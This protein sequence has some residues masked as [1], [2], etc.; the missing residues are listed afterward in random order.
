MVLNSRSTFTTYPKPPPPLAQ[1]RTE[2]RVYMGRQTWYLV[3]PSSTRPHLMHTPRRSHE[4]VSMQHSTLRL[5]PRGSRALS[6]E[7]KQAWCAKPR[8][9]VN[10]GGVPYLTPLNLRI[11]CVIQRIAAKRHHSLSATI[12]T[13]SSRSAAPTPTTR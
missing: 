9:C 6:G 12:T 8:D 7:L 2:R 13:W 4:H 5:N 1:R 10:P 3:F 11:A